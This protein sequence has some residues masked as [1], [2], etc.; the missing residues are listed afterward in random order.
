MTALREKPS[1]SPMIDA[2]I[3]SSHRSRRMISLS[4]VHLLMHSIIFLD[5]SKITNCLHFNHPEVT[6]HSTFERVQ[7][8]ARTTSLRDG[9]S[10]LF[11]IEAIHLGED[12]IAVIANEHIESLS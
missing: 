12:F 4:V 2:E 6:R 11:V 8:L 3:P 9:P 7:T 10:Q 5:L 1:S